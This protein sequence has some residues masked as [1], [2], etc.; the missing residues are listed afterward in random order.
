MNVKTVAEIHGIASAILTV[1]G[2]PGGELNRVWLV[3]QAEAILDRCNDDLAERAVED[4]LKVGAALA[5]AEEAE[6]SVPAGATGSGF[7]A[8][9]LHPDEGASEG[10]FR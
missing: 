4:P 9:P 5:L 1:V 8:N 7:H 6:G 3:A 10:E 2:T